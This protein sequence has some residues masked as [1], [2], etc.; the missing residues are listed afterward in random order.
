MAVLEGLD[1]GAEH[2][3][4]GSGVQVYFGSEFAGDRGELA[5]VDGVQVV[6]LPGERNQPVLLAG[7]AAAASR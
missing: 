5:E 1:V 7:L 6:A 4:G 3:T 2:A